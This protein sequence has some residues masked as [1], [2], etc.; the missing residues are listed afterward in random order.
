MYARMRMQGRASLLAYSKIREDG[1]MNP[2]FVS[3][4]YG[5]RRN[6]NRRSGNSS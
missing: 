3:Q 1:L 5:E 4:A 2:T 6:L